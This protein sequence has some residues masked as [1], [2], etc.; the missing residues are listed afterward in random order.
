MR[1]QLKIII[2]MLLLSLTACDHASAV[3]NDQYLDIQVLYTDDLRWSEKPLTSCLKNDAVMKYDGSNYVAFAIVGSYLTKKEVT[4]LT[5][6]EPPYYC[7]IDWERNAEAIGI[8]HLAYDLVLDSQFFKQLVKYYLDQGLPLIL[9]LSKDEQRIRKYVVVDGYS[10]GTDFQIHIIDPTNQDIHYLQELTVDQWETTSYQ[11]FDLGIVTKQELTE[12]EQQTLFE[13]LIG[14]WRISSRNQFFAYIEFYY[15]DAGNFRFFNGSYYD[16][17]PI[18]PDTQYIIR[19]RK[20]DQGWYELNM[21]IRETE[22]PNKSTEPT[23][24]P[25]SYFTAYINFEEGSNDEVLFFERGYLD[26][27][28]HYRGRYNKKASYYSAKLNINSLNNYE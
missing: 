18:Y 17:F 27:T 16:D 28:K 23:I 21:V 6:T 7:Q 5:M 8:K 12:I 26:N 14:T 2:V 4:P 13:R 9:Y 25:Q 3:I 1:K 24:Y 22:D 10:E 11:I 19:I 15:D 20:L